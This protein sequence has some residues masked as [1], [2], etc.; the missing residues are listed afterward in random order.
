MQL[1]Q[2]LARRTDSGFNAIVA[3]RLSASRVNRPGLG[4]ARLARYMKFNEEKIAVIVGA[5]TDD[6]RL[7]GKT[8]PKLRVAALKF[9]EG[10][11]ARIV[12]SGGE[13]LTFD[14]LAMLSP[15]GKGTILLRGLKSA[16]QAVKHFGAP[17]VPNSTTQC[18]PAPRPPTPPA[19]LGSPRPPPLS[20]PR[21]SRAAPCPSPPSAGLACGQ[22]AASLRWAAGAESRAASRSKGWGVGLHLFTT[23]IAS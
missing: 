19:V 3:K 23:P 8:F 1:Y 4:L 9:T 16:R 11:R 13:C 17:G 18:V 7:E 5:V 10:A 22:K 14:Q 12:A 15:Q 20:L 6:V 2:F 21:R